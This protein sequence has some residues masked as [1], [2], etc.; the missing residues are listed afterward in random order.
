MQAVQVT[1]LDKAA[2]FFVIRYLLFHELFFL[3]RKL[4]QVKLIAE[5]AGHGDIPAE[6]QRRNAADLVIRHCGDMRT[7]CAD[8]I[9]QTGAVLD[10]QAFRRIGVIAGPGLR[11]I[12]EH[13]RIEASTSAG[14][15]LEENMREVRR[16]SL[17]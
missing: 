12:V 1:L 6:G 14:A 15:A 7:H 16:Q 13:A 8:R 10:L 2:D 9:Y 3:I 11:H 4:R 17:D 5:V